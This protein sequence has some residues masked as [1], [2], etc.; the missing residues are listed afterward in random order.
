[1]WIDSQLP[2]GGAGGSDAE[3]TEEEIRDEAQEQL[4]KSDVDI[5]GCSCSAQ[6]APTPDRL[7]A[8]LGM[9]A[10]LGGLMYR[11]RKG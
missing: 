4:S 10:L 7:A 1:M 5:V 3:M 11:R 6:P 9:W 2:I 8:Q